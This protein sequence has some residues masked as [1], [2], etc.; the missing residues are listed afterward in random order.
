MRR[1]AG[2]IA[3]AL[4][5]CRVGFDEVPPDGSVD[6][7]DAMPDAA[8]CFGSQVKVCFDVLPRGPVMLDA[9][10]DIDTERSP[11]CDQHNDR[12]V[13]FCVVAGTDFTLSSGAMIRGHGKKPL[14]LLAMNTIDV[15][16]AIDV[17]SVCGP[18][19]LSG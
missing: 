19:S 17:S 10:T 5:G 11:L 14:V 13:E 6:A 3:F 15:K 2:W 1:R 18:G 4:I 9:D 8:G 16:G 12:M 7:I